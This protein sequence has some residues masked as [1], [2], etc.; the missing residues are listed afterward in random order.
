[1]TCFWKVVTEPHKEAWTVPTTEAIDFSDL[2]LRLYI[3]RLR[4]SLKLKLVKSW[5]LDPVHTLLVCLAGLVE[6][7]G[8]QDGNNNQ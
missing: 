6:Q 4:E 2:D 5:K 8:S 1:M 7:E 3:L